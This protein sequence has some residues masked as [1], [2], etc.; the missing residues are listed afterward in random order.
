MKLKVNYY[1]L[2][3]GQDFVEFCKNETDLLLEC[4]KQNEKHFINTEAAPIV[5]DENNQTE[6]ENI[7][8]PINEPEKGKRKE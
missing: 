8:T 6:N 3:A 4:T 7:E 2:L 1:Y 5:L